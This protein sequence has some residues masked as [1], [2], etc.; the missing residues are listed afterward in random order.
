MSIEQLS[1]GLW[2]PSGDAQI[3]QWREKGHP[4]MQDKCL[5]QFVEWCEKN[6]KKFKLIL[7]IGA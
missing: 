3:E 2:V 5:N 1:N 6:N 7:D 4:H